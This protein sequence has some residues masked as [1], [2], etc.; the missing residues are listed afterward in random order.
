MLREHSKRLR[1]TTTLSIQHLKSFDLALLLVYLVFEGLLRLGVL[2]IPLLILLRQSKIHFLVKFCG[3]VWHKLGNCFD[4]SPPCL[5]F[6]LNIFSLKCEQLL[7]P[8]DWLVG[9]FLIF[10]PNI[11]NLVTN[12][13]KAIVLFLLD[14]FSG[15]LRYGRNGVDKLLLTTAMVFSFRTLFGTFASVT[16]ENDFYTFISNMLFKLIDRPKHFV[17]STV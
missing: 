15:V 13:D 2:L 6:F 11:E 9:S 14:S 8:F 7:D 1:N 17:W 16:S 3:K 5:S 4:L 12:T 10:F